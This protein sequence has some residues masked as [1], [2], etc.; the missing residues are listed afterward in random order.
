MDAKILFVLGL[1]PRAEYGVEIDD[2]E[3]EYLGSDVGGTLVI[4]GP[5]GVNAGVRISLVQ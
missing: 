1:M 4:S 3:L 5:E 2:Q